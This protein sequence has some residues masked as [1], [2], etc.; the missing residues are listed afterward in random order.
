[1]SERV[2]ALCKKPIVGP[3]YTGGASGLGGRFHYECLHYPEQVL[4]QIN[5]EAEVGE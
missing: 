2:C 3:A 1:M 4:A 5:E